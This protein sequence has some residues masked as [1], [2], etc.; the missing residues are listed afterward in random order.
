MKTEGQ[1]MQSERESR[2]ST[3]Q[4]SLG[5]LENAKINRTLRNDKDAWQESRKAVGKKYLMLKLLGKDPGYERL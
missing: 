1:E 4:K 5:V 3:K 2:Q